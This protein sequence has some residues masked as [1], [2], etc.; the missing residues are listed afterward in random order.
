VKTVLDKKVI[1]ANIIRVPL[2]RNIFFSCLAIAIVFPVYSILYVYPSFI[3]LLIESTEDDAVLTARHLTRVIIPEDT[4][5]KLD[6]LPDELV[7]KIEAL[8]HDFNLEKLKIFLNS[9]EIIY[10]TALEDVGTFNR[11]IYFHDIV[12]KGNVHTNIVRKDMASL[13]GRMVKFDVVETYVPFMR[14]NR[15]AGAF[16]IYYDITEKRETLNTLLSHSSLILYVIAVSLLISVIVILFNASKTMIER[17]N[18]EDALRKA[19]MELEQRVEE[20]TSALSQANQELHQQI[21]ERHRVAQA[22]RESGERLHV[23]SSHLLTAQER[24]RRRISLELHDEL[25]QSLTV[26][27]L[28]LRGMQRNLEKDQ[29]ALQDGCENTLKY[30]DQIIDN[31]R[32][33]SRDLSPSILEDLGLTAALRWLLQDFAKHS[34]I[35]TSVEIPD[36]DKR[37]SKDAQIIIYRIFQEALTNVGKHARATAVVAVA[38]ETEN[39][40]DFR[41]EDNGKGFDIN[42]IESRPSMEQSLGL[43][44]MDERVRML[45]GTL[46]IDAEEGAGTKIF[47]TVPDDTEEGGR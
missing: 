43:V 7:E 23:L 1:L 22:L 3:E 2:L 21:E 14:G 39:R 37:F 20:R 29:K 12:A 25:G 40:I 44:A 34:N 26:L 47:F 13:E 5:L 41:I 32:R 8:A 31:V 18:A 27:K 17:A 24:E 4:N 15:F 35:N 6:S 38:E 10:S 11:E 45:G 36:I 16:E 19:H 33:L 46:W 28:Q 9:G 42:Q 30:V